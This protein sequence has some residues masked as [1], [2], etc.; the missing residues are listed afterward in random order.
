M[1]A[2]ADL[3]QLP[4]LEEIKARVIAFAED[5]Q[6]K[7]KNFIPGEPSERWLEIIPRSID[8]FLSNITTTA[9]RMFFLEL[10]TDPGDAGDLSTDQTPRPGF[11]SALGAGWYGVTRGQATY[12]PGV[13]TLTNTGTLPATISAYDLTFQ[14]SSAGADGGYPTYRN[15]TDATVYTGPGATLTLAPSASATIPIIAEQAGSVA[16]ASPGE[17]S[18]VVTNSFGTFSVTNANP[19]IGADREERALYISR[20]RLQSGAASPNGA[21]DAYR[22]AS[23]TGADGKPLQLWDGTGA[24]TVNRVF[25]SPDS[26]TGEV[27]IYLANST[28]PASTV[29]VSSANGNIN[30]ITIADTNGVVWNPN[31]IGVV[32]DGIVLGPTV[33]DTKTQAPGPAKAIATNV[34]FL[35][36]TVRIKAIPGVASLTLIRDIHVAIEA[37]ESLYFETIPI[38]GLDQV[39]GAGVV[40]RNDLEAVLKDSYPGLYAA[41]LTKPSSVTQVISLGHVAVYVGPPVVSA[42]ADNG[43]GEVRLTVDKDLTGLAQVQIWEAVTGGSGTP[44]SIVGTWNFTYISA[45]QID[46]DGSVFPPG[47]TFTSCS[48]SAIIVTV[49]S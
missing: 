39:A 40:Y 35:A 7:V 26:S 36:G 18:V 4:T 6:L 11:L 30:G 17:I 44:L 14:R 10:A 2:F 9:V 29:E 28:G 20:C 45:T 15:E 5:A 19:V 22:Y 32:P 34:G 33:T 46:L 37:A 43:S 41:N 8:A 12:A 24:T 27:L 42:A 1:V 38:G 31:P 25:V 49:A 16:N 3:L 13:V 21:A 23:T 47:G 48:L